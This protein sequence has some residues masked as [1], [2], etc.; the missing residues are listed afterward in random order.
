MIAFDVT[1]L[2][3]K[4]AEVRW[5][6]G[7]FKIKAVPGEEKFADWLEDWLKEPR[8][9]FTLDKGYIKLTGEHPI[10]FQRTLLTLPLFLE[11]LE[12]SGDWDAYWAEV[13]R[14]GIFYSPRKE[15]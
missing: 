9:W 6:K 1:F 8:K 15:K 3:R 5:S 4:I 11:G 7:K 10:G 14:E 2:D 12:V 13:D